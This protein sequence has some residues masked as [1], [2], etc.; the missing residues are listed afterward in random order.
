MSKQIKNETEKAQDRPETHQGNQQIAGQDPANVFN[1]RRVKSG[2]WWP[3]E[4]W[5]ERREI[6]KAI[7][8]HVLAFTILIGLLVVV[9][10]LIKISDLSPERKEILDTIDF[11]GIVLALGI[12]SISFIYTLVSDAVATARRKNEAE[13]L[14]RLRMKRKL[15]KETQLSEEEANKV[16]LQEIKKM[17][18]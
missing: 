10:Y 2:E 9:H 14:L 16:I 1:K 4:I 13:R 17:G 11:Y 5:K 12:F 6:F 15:I 8:E 3:I 7:V 18:K